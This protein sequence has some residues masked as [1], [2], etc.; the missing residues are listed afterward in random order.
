MTIFR[1]RRTE[2]DDRPRALHGRENLERLLV[3][4]GLIVFGAY[5]WE[6]KESDLAF[7][8]AILFVL[9]ALLEIRSKLESIR[10]MLAMDFDLKI[11]Q[12]LYRRRRDE[13]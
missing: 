10:F 11:E 6:R 4:A 3:T 9:W 1:R 7:F 5:A 12:G 8:A 13:V 2:D